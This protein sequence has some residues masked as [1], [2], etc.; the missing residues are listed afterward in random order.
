MTLVIKIKTWTVKPKRVHQNCTSFE[1]YYG[2]EANG[3]SKFACQCDHKCDQEEGNL[4]LAKA[5]IS[6]F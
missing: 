3:I 5:A 6:Y 4:S 2:S 1:K